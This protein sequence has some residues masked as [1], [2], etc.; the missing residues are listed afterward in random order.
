MEWLAQFS[1]LLAFAGAGLAQAGRIPNSSL[2]TMGQPTFVRPALQAGSHVSEF[3]ATKTDYPNQLFKF[4]AQ[5]RFFRGWQEL[6]P[7]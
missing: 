4:D 2:T 1:C 5:I 6:V 7:R 3:S